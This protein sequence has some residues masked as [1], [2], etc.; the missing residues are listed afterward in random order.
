MARARET[1][2]E[3]WN[4]SH[5]QSVKSHEYEMT[6]ADM[7]RRMSIQYLRQEA[8]TPFWR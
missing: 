5:L 1:A 8:R 2:E 6:F 3:K 7:I 4:K